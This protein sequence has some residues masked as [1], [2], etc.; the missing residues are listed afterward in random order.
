MAREWPIPPNDSTIQ[1]IGDTH[2]GGWPAA[3]Y[4][5]MMDDMGHALVGRVTAHVQVGDVTN[6][7]LEAED[8]LAIAWLDQLPG[9]WHVVIGAHDVEGNIRTGAEWAAAY[10]LESQ[11]YVQDFGFARMIVIGAPTDTNVMPQATLDFL[12]ESLNASSDPA[13]IACHFPLYDTVTGDVGDNY[14]S[15]ESAFHCKPDTDIRTILADYPQAK[16]W[17]A[18][19]TH[20]RITAPGFVKDEDIGGRTLVS[21]NASSPW[22]QGRST[23]AKHTPIESVFVTYL[24]DRIEVRYRNHGAGV[25][26]GPEGV[27]VTTVML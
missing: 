17:L 23:A 1:L 2:F 27:R 8:D 13:M 5:K 14:S 4:T 19:H 6:N 20:S 3:R 11:N 26:T 12:D 15:L 16:A 7:G 24:D 22:Y 21:V 10:G 9:P 18:G 25:W